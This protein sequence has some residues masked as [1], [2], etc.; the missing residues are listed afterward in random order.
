MING[1]IRQREEEL[2]PRIR[3]ELPKG[4]EMRGNLVEITPDCVC[5]GL[6]NGLTGYIP[7][8]YIEESGCKYTD[9]TKSIEPGCRLW[10]DLAPC[11]R[12]PRTLVLRH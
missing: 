9:F 6:P 5:V 3:A 1:S 8:Q 10:G 2:W 12:L 4:T 7:R 11:L